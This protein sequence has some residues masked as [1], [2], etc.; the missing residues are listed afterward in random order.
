MTRDQDQSA[1]RAHGIVYRLDA[2]P[3]AAQNLS[4]ARLSL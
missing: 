4:R 1:P 2:A 3:A